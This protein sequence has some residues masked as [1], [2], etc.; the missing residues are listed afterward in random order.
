MHTNANGLLLLIGSLSTVIGNF[1]CIICCYS[2][3]EVIYISVRMD[4]VE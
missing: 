2:H 3:A 4:S 1:H